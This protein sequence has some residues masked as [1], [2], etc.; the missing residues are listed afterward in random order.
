MSRNDAR[1]RGIALVTVLL[2]LSLALLLV[3]GMLRGQVTSSRSTAMQVQHKQLW[4]AALGAE[5]MAV[6]R[7]EQ[8]LRTLNEA[9]WRAPQRDLAFADAR[10]DL[11]IEDLAGRFNIGSI[12][13][14]QHPPKIQI[15][16]WQRLLK[17]LQL[18]ATLLVP[19]ANESE[20][21]TPVARGRVVV[22]M[23][24]DIGLLRLREG[25]NAQVLRTLEPWVVWLPA[26]V[27]LNVNTASPTVLATLGLEQTVVDRL[28]AQ[29]LK[30]IGEL[31]R[32][33]GQGNEPFNVQGLTT[34]SQW[35][36]VHLVVR[37]GPRVLHSRSDLFVD[38]K[39]QKISVV[40][41]A[42]KPAAEVE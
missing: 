20:P 14:L 33:A 39:T 41:R 10:V 37:L 13:D 36:R 29:P 35:Y 23:A 4:Q 34:T 25:I 3:G 19:Q 21:S 11:H 1:Q 38:P 18:P 31:G 8:A 6:A 7:L 24:A 28:A 2:V 30:G 42:I 16:R 22:P 9:D 5:H 40:R 17:T 12:V 32:L 27:G 26:Q 15:E